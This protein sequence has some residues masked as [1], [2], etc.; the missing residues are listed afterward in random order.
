MRRIAIILGASLAL[1]A[2]AAAHAQAGSGDA[3]DTGSRIQPEKP[4]GVKPVSRAEYDERVEKLFK[5]GDSNRDG[6]ITLDEYNAV[7][8][9]SKERAISAR[10]ARIDTNRDQALSLAEFA[11][12]QRG[13]GAAVLV[14]GAESSGGG[15]IAEEIRIDLSTNHTDQL[16]ARV[17][18]PLTAT[19]LVEAN[20][21]Y[22]GGVSLAEFIAWEGQQFE[23]GD[24][25]N[26]TWLEQIEIDDLNGGANIAQPNG[27]PAGPPPG[28]RP[29]GPPPGN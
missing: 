24:K 16:V 5:A 7:I 21:D 17:I 15:L 26:D 29:S 6:T 2:G 25:N 18:R 28:G 22:D 9:A 11:T 1:C 20:T 3:P 12:W 13:V 10:F 23:K 14:E 4:K 27:R 8:S 19:A